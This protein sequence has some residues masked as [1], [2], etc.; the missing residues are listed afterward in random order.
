MRIA[1]VAVALAAALAP[2]NSP[3]TEWIWV[4][5]KAAEGERAAFRKAFEAKEVAGAVLAVTCDNAFTAWVNGEQV[6]QGD[7]WQKVVRVDVKKL[8]RD[9]RNVIAIEGRNG[10]GVAALLARLELKS[11][12][13]KKWAVVTDPSWDATLKP[14]EGWQKP[15]AETKGW[16]KAVSLGNHGRPP[17]GTVLDGKAAEPE[18]Q[19]TGA[20]KIKVRD[21]FKVELLYT[22]PK[23]TQGSWVALGLD[24]K[25][26][27]IASDQGN[28]GLY[29]IVVDGTKVDVRKIGV[30]VSGAQGICW[31][32]GALY[33][34]LN[35]KGAGLWRI[36]D[37][38]GDDHLDKAEHLMALKG[39]G[40]HGPH[41]VIPTEDGKALYVVGGNHTAPPDDLTGS[42]IPTTWNEDL[43]L[44]RLWDAK[45][46][47][48]GILAP[49][50]WI[51][52]VSPDGKERVMWSVGY[53]NQYDIALN[54]HGELFTFDSD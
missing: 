11:A 20:D 9:G 23:A 53:R 31:A 28:L 41:A 1:A 4:S 13:G 51:A 30:P 29:R 42:T 40:E 36:T 49:G 17:W 27:L 52:R 14:G 45:G 44:P 2:Q 33:V 6:A 34:N 24:G 38:D 54:R 35:G 32:F 3:P 25:G 15:D 5:S 50:G 21:G 46:H 47:A 37:T 43:L 16:T 39:G 22:V 8:L 12:D 18:A 26:R 7:D 10:D 19:A 48:R